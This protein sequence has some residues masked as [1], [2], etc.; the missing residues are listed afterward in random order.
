MY[1]ALYMVRTQVYLTEAQKRLLERKA[2]ALG[3]PVAEL[4]RRAIDGYLGG[5]AAEA[6]PADALERTLG[7]LPGIEVPPRTEWDRFDRAWERTR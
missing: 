4:I 3:E 6:D 7:A 5:Y 2:R 1:T